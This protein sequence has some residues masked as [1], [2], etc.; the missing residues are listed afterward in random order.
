M[1]VRA[2]GSRIWATCL[3]LGLNL[4]KSSS[5][6]RGG[7]QNLSNGPR[8]RSGLWGSTSLCSTWWISP[9][10]KS[11]CLRVI[12]AQRPGIMTSSLFVVVD[13]YSALSETSL[14]FG[15]LRVSRRPGACFWRVPLRIKL[16]ILAKC[17]VTRRFFKPPPVDEK[18]RRRSLERLGM[19]P[20]STEVFC[21]S[22]SSVFPTTFPNLEITIF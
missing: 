16:N 17:C 12:G 1:Q 2:Q 5:T 6:S 13:Y 18:I 14:A 3:A 21:S 10:M 11:L 8:F 15:L 4:W 9:R 7:D 22:S 19:P 20:C